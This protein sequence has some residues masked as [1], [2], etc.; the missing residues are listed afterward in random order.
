MGYYGFDRLLYGYTQYLTENA[1][2]DPEDFIILSSMPRRYV[3][4][5]VFG[6]IYFHAPMLRWSIENTGSCSWGL[7]AERLSADAMTDG[8]RKVY[9]YNQRNGVKAG[10]TISFK[11]VSSR[12]KGSIALIGRKDISQA[13]LDEIWGEHG[14]DIQLINNVAHLKILTLPYSNY[15][16]NLTSRQREVL[17]W[18]SDGKTIQ[19]I[20]VL[21]KR[22]PATVEK[23]L[24]LARESLNVETTAQ[25]VLKASFLNQMFI[26]EAEA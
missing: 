25:A 6:G 7:L 15:K 18:V 23:H 1:Y 9:D 16:R 13:E 4:E 12:V 21:L 14:D 24:R 17:E 8:E 20:A 11:S 5:F 26:R 2:G 19:D 22:K 10:Y 3:E